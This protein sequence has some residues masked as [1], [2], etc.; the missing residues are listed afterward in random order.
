MQ[1]RKFQNEITN[2]LI[3]GNFENSER[4]LGTRKI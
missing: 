4:I 2:Q 3:Q 1:A